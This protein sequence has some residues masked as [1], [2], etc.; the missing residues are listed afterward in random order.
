[1]LASCTITVATDFTGLDVNAIN[2]L[3][4]SMREKEI[5]YR[6]V[7][8]TLTYLA[9]DATENPELKEIVQGP[10]ALRSDTVILR[11]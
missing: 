11:R 3:R 1:M 4:H 10:T 8:N 7:K 6:V 5:E 2:E 9:A